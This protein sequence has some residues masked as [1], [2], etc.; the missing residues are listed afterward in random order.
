[1]G[2]GALF[3]G[4]KRPGREADLWSPFSAEVKNAWSYNHYPYALIALCL[5]KHRDN[6]DINNNMKN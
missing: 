5:I 6:N 2:T 3:S 1:M 4:V